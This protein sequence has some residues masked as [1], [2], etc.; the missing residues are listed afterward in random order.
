MSSKGNTSAVCCFTGTLSGARRL[1]RLRSAVTSRD[2]TLCAGTAAAAAAPGETLRTRFN[3]YALTKA[4]R[5]GP[6]REP[7]KD[8]L[9]A[10]LQ[11]A[12]GQLCYR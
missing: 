1:P 12:G 2:P 8:A 6:V 11:A 10:Q 3:K 4:G 7:H 9:F 5:L